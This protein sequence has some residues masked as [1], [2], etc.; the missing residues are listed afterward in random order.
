MDKPMTTKQIKAR[1]RIRHT[2]A[3]AAATRAWATYAA[4]VAGGLPDRASRAWD[5]YTA[6]VDQAAAMADAKKASK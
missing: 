4:C 6:A 1:A 5:D 2:V 3:V